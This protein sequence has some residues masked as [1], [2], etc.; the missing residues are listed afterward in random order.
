MEKK[1]KK[2]D[3]DRV[4]LKQLRDER[5]ALLSSPAMLLAI[6]QHALSLPGPLVRAAQ[7]R[8]Q[9]VGGHTQ[10]GVK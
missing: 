3:Q 2:F 6:S 1:K 10:G 5:E 8:L 9:G 4:E 7:R